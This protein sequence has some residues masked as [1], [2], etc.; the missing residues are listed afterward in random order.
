MENV[1]AQN[2]ENIGNNVIVSK[3][4]WELFVVQ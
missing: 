1:M 2:K 3:I 4:G